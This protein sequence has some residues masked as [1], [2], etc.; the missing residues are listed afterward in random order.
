MKFVRALVELVVLVILVLISVQNYSVVTQTLVF[1]LNLGFLGTWQI[2][3]VS[4]GVLFIIALLLGG[5][6]VGFYGF[7]E[8]LRLRR[9]YREAVSRGKYEE[10]ELDSYTSAKSQESYPLPAEPLDEDES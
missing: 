5:F 3:P 8:Y 6:F 4:V 10:H 1:K 9:K 7:F 2:G